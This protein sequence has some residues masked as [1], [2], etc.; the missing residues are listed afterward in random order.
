MS[1]TAGVVMVAVAADGEVGIDVEALDADVSCED[2]AERFFTRGEH[3]ALLAMEKEERV[4]AFFRGWTRKESLLKATGEGIGA[5]LNSVEVPLYFS[6]VPIRV[7]PWMLHDI[8]MPPT[9][10]ATLAIQAANPQLHFWSVTGGGG[11]L[12]GVKLCLYDGPK[13]RGFQAGGGD[14]GQQAVYGRVGFGGGQLQGV[15]Q[16]DQVAEL[17][18]VFQGVALGASR[19]D[20]RGRI[21]LSRCFCRRCRRLGGTFEFP[22]RC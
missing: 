17:V 20:N 6:D 1:H 21:W 5:G 13:F 19:R 22:G 9:H 16:V 11:G 2:I 18:D 7:G 10:S 14:E 3:A 12:G 4:P 8:A 15:N